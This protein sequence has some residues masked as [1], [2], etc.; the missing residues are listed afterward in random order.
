MHCIFLN[1]VESSV[2]DG[3]LDLVS[4][5]K[6]TMVTHV[7]SKHTLINRSFGVVRFGHGLVEANI[8][9]LL[10]FLT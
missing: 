2:D 6:S 7:N 1:I 5:L 9:C 3:H 8:S 4:D 10:V